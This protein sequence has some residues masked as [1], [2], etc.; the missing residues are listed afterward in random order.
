MNETESTKHFEDDE[1]FIAYL[2]G[3]SG[4]VDLSVF[5]FSNPFVEETKEEFK[6]SS[7]NLKS[8]D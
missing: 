4:E 2:S 7:L 6:V 8:L 5:R 3:Q 1:T